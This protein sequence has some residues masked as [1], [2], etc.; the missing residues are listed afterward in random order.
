[1][2]TPQTAVTLL[3]MDIQRAE[4]IAQAMNTAPEMKRDD[5]PW[6]MQD[7]IGAAL[8]RGLTAMTQT[9]IWEVKP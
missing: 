8:D 1:M 6:T 4:R 9:Y 3:P 2:T 5:H 7:V